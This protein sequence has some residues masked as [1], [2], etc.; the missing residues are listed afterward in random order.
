MS[1]SSTPGC[2]RSRPKNYPRDSDRTVVGS[3]ASTHAEQEAP[4]SRAIAPSNSGATG[5]GRTA[6]QPGGALP[7]RRGGMADE[8]G[9]RGEGFGRV[10]SQL[11]RMDAVTASFVDAIAA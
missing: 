8:G 3:R 1:G 4:G 5:T 10:D 11:A 2:E 7:E 9:R 6:P